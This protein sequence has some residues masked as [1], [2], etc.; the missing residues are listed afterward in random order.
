MASLRSDDLC[1]R[2]PQVDGQLGEPILA[3]Y[4]EKYSRPEMDAVVLRVSVPE[5]QG[6]D[7]RPWLHALNPRTY[8]G[9]LNATG[10]MHLPPNL[11]NALVMASTRLE[12]PV[13]GADPPRRY[14]VPNAFVLSNTDDAR[15]GISGSVVLCEDGVIGLA[16]FARAGSAQVGRQG[17]VVPVTT[18]SDGW[19]ALTEIVE[20]FVDSSLRDAAIVKRSRL[21]EVGDDLVISRKGFRGDVYLQRAADQQADNALEKCG[22]VMI[23]GRPGSGKTRLA[24]RLLQ[25]QPDTV[26]VIPRHSQPPAKFELSVPVGVRV[27]A[28]FD[29]L[30]RSAITADPLAWQRRIQETSGCRCLMICISGDGREW[31]QV[32]RQHEALST[33]LSVEAHIFTSRVGD[34]GADMSEAE[35][36]LL[37]EMLGIPGDKFKSNFGGT[38]GSLTLDLEGMSKRYEEMKGQEQLGILMNTALDAAK[39]LHEADIPR[40]PVALMEAVASRIIVG[41]QI[42]PQAWNTVLNRTDAEGFGRVNEVGEFQ[43]YHPYLDQCVGYTPLGKNVEALVPILKEGKNYEAL[44]YVGTALTMKYESGEAGADALN[45]ASESGIPAPYGTLNFVSAMLARNDDPDAEKKIRDAIAAGDKDAY[46]SLAMYLSGKPGR[47]KDAEQAFSDAF[48]AG[49]GSHMNYANFVAHQPGREKDAERA[50][51]KAADAAADAPFERALVSWD[52]AKL[53]GRQPTRLGEAEQEYKAAIGGIPDPGL[54]ATVTCELA[55]LLGRQLGR[56]K[57]AEDL[58]RETARGGW[59][60]AYYELGK[61]LTSQGGRE[62]EAEKSYRDALAGGNKR[63]NLGLAELLAQQEERQAEAEQLFRDAMSAHVKGARGN[64]GLWLV[65]QGGREREAEQVAREAIQAGDPRATMVLGLAIWREKGKEREAEKAF[66]EAIQSGFESATYSLG[67]LLAGQPG[68]EPEAEAAYRR[69]IASGVQEAHLQLGIFLMRRDHPKEAEEAFRAAIAAGEIQAHFYLAG[70][71]V[72][73]EGREEEA[74]RS[75]RDAADAG[76]ERAYRFVGMALAGEAGREREAEE[77]F[78]RAIKAGDVEAYE[79][80]GDLLAGLPRRKKDAELAYKGAIQSGIPNA[81]AGLNKLLGR[82][83]RAKRAS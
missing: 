78:Q 61:F 55:K 49:V 36:Q 4:F 10:L 33:F 59:P 25:A 19:P 57:E 6:A 1:V 74:F 62:R 23:V 43:I 42:K 45:T 81:E 30:T 53:L 67:K 31:D 71:L 20:P 51:R 65:Q 15:P 64:Y 58:F 83:R 18:W 38:P 13:E 9:S 27:V 82:K 5:G 35:G 41:E 32:K 80:L 77:F 40:I 34:K 44:H 16:H 46:D 29:D 12:V 48:A 3:S 2:I 66:Q 73:Q 52:F 39:L 22:G 70:C 26:A 37:A 68:R 79:N 8:N 47:E 28:V 76:D 24:L 17:F 14:L 69:A 63:A 75:F 60:Q 50:Y 7:D 56:E 72:V 54:R 21:L 11:F